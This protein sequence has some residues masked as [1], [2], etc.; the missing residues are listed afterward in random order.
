MV[1]IVN[2][3]VQLMNN[4][5]RFV[6]IMKRSKRPFEPD[7][8]NEKNYSWNDPKLQKHI[9]EGGNIGI[10][11][12]N[13][14][15]VIDADTEELKGVIENRLPETFTIRTGSGGY[16]YYYFSGKWGRSVDR[17]RLGV[18]NS[19]RPMIIPVHNNFLDP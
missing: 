13:G 1:E 9:K 17:H 14:L 6:L 5:F 7:W 11:C 2:L 19:L 10:L 18:I 4:V 3:P 8:Q 12:G 15:I 16:H